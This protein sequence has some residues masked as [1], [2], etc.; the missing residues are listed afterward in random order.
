MGHEPSPSPRR[1]AGVSRP[2]GV[3][4]FRETG[5]RTA[6]LLVAARPGRPSGPSGTAR[7]PGLFR[8]LLAMT[9]LIGMLRTGIAQDS[10]KQPRDTETYASRIS[11]AAG[12]WERDDVA[13]A[14]RLLQECAAQPGE[15]DVRGFK[16]LLLSRIVT[17][18]LQ[19]WLK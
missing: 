12:A 6:R 18:T 11:A 13:L 10:A 9:L 2:V 4:R 16:W 1:A 8:A 19:P 3:R 14:K 5:T 15:A 17:Q 7:P